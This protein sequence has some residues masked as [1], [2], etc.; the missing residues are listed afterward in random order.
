MELNLGC[1][2][3]THSITKRQSSRG[4][5][6]LCNVVCFTNNYPLK[7]LNYVNDKCC[8]TMK[9]YQAG[10]HTAS[11]YCSVA[12]RYRYLNIF[13]VSR[14][15]PYLSVSALLFSFC[16]VFL[17]ILGSFLVSNSLVGEL[18]TKRNNESDVSK[19]KTLEFTIY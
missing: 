19:F 10:Y 11:V 6:G 13:P 4:T 12:H 17:C 2:T 3:L 18:V 5:Q 14:T 7:I 8:S 16:G 1:V 15:R 9:N